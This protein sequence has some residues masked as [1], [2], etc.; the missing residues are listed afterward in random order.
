MLER[1]VKVKTV[2]WAKEMVELYNHSGTNRFLNSYILDTH[3]GVASCARKELPE[4]AEKVLTLKISG[5]KDVPESI[6]IEGVE[7]KG[8]I[9]PFKQVWIKTAFD[10]ETELIG[11]S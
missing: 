10:P 3:N 1:Y 8:Y 6:H 7:R 11:L 5:N 2:P 4:K 9:C